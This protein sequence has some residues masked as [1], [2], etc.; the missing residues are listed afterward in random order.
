MGAHAY[1]YSVDFEEDDNVALQKLRQREFLAGRYNPVQMF[2]DFEALEDEPP[3]AQHDSIEEAIEAAEADGTRSIL[4]LTRVD[5]NPDFC[6]AERIN[7]Q[8][9]IEI[10]GT[11][12]PTEEV[13]QEKFYD[14]FELIERGQGICFP[15]YDNDKP[16]ELVFMGY[17][18]D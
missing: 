9:L 7:P 16:K 13:V 8:R 11:D 2:P 15:V 6:V 12:K 4:D 14:L 10:F 18:F 1:Y 5:D 3:G 17:S